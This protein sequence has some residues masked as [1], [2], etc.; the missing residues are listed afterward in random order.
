LNVYSEKI[1][2]A[3]RELR[4]AAE[5]ERQR[6]EI[7]DIGLVAFAAKGYD[8]T[9]MNEIAEVSGYSVGHIYNVIGNK[10]ELFEAVVSREADAL[11]DLI[12]E[13]F[14]GFDGEPA[15]ECIDSLIE[16]SLR[17]FDTHQLFFRI[18][19]NETDGIRIS[20]AHLKTTKLE[21]RHQT[22]NKGI[23]GLFKRAVEEGTASTLSPDDMATV[24][25]EL[26]KGFV[27]RWAQ[28][29]YPGKIS[30]KAD[31]IK[32]ILWNGIKR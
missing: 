14:A 16:T 12:D 28:K 24:F 21:K 17:F 23:R 13:A 11:F 19:L 7:L 8:G 3:K 27:A 9:S 10:E 26:I 4:K 2:V 32:H 31:V 6:N 15:K 1:M 18:Y 29:G 5:R 25:D 22:M 20:S 30:N